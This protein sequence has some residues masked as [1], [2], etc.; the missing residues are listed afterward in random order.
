M[1]TRAGVRHLLPPLVG[2][3][4]LIRWLRSQRW[5]VPPSKN[6][7]IDKI[8]AQLQRVAFP[9]EARSRVVVE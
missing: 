1:M 7:E 4:S 9:I 5:F 8:D 6:S 2:Y 3:K